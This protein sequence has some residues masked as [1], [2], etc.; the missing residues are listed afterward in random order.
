MTPRSEIARNEAFFRAVNEG[1]AEA[2]GRVESEEAEF[3]CECG[4]ARCSH[5]IE[6]P[7]DEYEQVRESPTQFLVKRGH[8][9]PE[10]EE[11][12]QRR[13]RYTIVEKVDRVAARI[14]RRLNSRRPRPA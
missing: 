3:L 5:R 2:S 6:V 4:D 9:M 11:G 13:R 12:V 1:I 7:L 14:V 8:V 10:V